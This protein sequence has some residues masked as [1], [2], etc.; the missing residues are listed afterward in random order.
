MFKFLPRKIILL[1][2]GDVFLVTVSIYL[3]YLI[4]LQEYKDVLSIYTGASVFTIT[5]YCLHF[6]IADLYNFS[7]NFKSPS[8]LFRSFITV[9]IATGFI[10]T[11]FYLFPNWKYG[12]GLFALTGFLVFLLT[13]FWRILVLKLYDLVRKPAKLLILGAG[14]SGRALYDVLC[15]KK[16]YSIIGFLDDDPQKNGMTIGS[17]RVLGDT[18]MLESLIRDN[19]INSIVVAITH[20]KSPELFKRLIFAKFRGLTLY[21]MPALY[22]D[23]TGK[24]PVFHISDVWF[25]H[26][27]IYGVKINLYNRKIKW[28]L[29][30]SLAFLLC[31][32]AVPIMLLTALIIKLDSRG[33]VLYHQRRVGK[34]GEVFRLVK[35]RSMRA[36]AES[37]GAAVWADKGDCRI[38]RVG[39]VIRLL[40]I[41]EL[42]QLWNVLKGEMS[43]VG[44]RPE[45]PEF[46]KTLSEEIPF[47]SLRHSVKPGITGWAQVNYR[48]GASSEDTIEKLQY[49]LYYIKNMS[50]FLDI[51]ILFETIKVVLFGKGA[52]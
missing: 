7:Y 17:S 37:S 2:T 4:R 15:N 21:D 48:Y 51:L 25:E 23:V 34:D 36:D 28:V 16:R 11:T 20:D 6:Y 46:V 50:F 24:I 3:A 19:N 40:R 13:A 41:D 9:I 8:F 1:F 35:L 30:K 18:S 10:G 32:V 49:D 12:R 47:F 27:D 43:F 22:E 52:R 33:P 44:P 39:R 26:A 29:D 38:T 14:S 31:I 5:I 42:P 45:R